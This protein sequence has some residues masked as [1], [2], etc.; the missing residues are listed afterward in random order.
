MVLQTYKKH[1]RILWRII[2]QQIWQ[3]RRNGQ[4]SRDI[5]P[6]KTESRRNRSTEQTIT[7]IEIEYVINILPTNKSPGPDGFTGEFYQTYKEELTL[8]LL[9]LFQK[10]EE[11]GALPKTFYEAANALI[12]NPKIPPKKKTIGQYLWWI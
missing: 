8:I 11:K 4:L 6:V 9:K 12:P 5:Q 2:C 7:R 1:K 3:P 10:V